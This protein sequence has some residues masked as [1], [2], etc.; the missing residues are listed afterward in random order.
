[1]SRPVRLVVR[2]TPRAGVD[3]VDGADESGRL[4]VRVRAAP[5]AGAANVALLKVVAADLD[6]APS[7]IRIVN[8]AA[9]RQKLIELSGVAAA[10]MAARW[11]GVDLA[12]T[13]LGSGG[14]RA[15]RHPR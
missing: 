4:K 9:G 5:A 13:A 7:R 2:V 3:A 8:G 6:I 10:T 14:W 15:R 11:P 12:D 1:M